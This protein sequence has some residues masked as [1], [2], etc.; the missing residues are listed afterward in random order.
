MKKGNKSFLLLKTLKNTENAHLCKN[1]PFPLPIK[2]VKTSLRILFFCAIGTNGLIRSQSKPDLL[3][4][5]TDTCFFN[6]QIFI[7][8]SFFS[9]PL[10]NLLFH[11]FF[12]KKKLQSYNPTG[13][14]H[15]ILGSEQLVGSV[16]HVTPESPV[17]KKSIMTHGCAGGGAGSSSC[18]SSCCRSVSQR[19]CNAAA[20]DSC[21]CKQ[22]WAL[23][24][25]LIFS[26]MKK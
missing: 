4:Y 20:A 8:L 9:Y 1:L 17:Q 16:A 21:T 7:P 23:A 12:I 14:H 15:P 13:P 26:L 11:I 6:I 19:P 2:S 24:V 22:S 3:L 25:F 5:P 18:C 10:V